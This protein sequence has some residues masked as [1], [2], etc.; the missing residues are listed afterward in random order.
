VNR[1]RAAKMIDLGLMAEHGQAMIEL[2]RADGTLP[3]LAD[4]ESLVIPMICRNFFDRN[5]AAC[6]NFQN[7]S[8]YSKRLILEWTWKRA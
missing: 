3:V 4:G 7:F 1:Q 8:P 6:K 2:A 5:D